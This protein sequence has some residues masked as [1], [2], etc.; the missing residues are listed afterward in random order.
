MSCGAI[1][2]ADVREST[3]ALRCTGCVSIIAVKC[4]CSQHRPG[5]NGGTWWD[6][7]YLKY[8]EKKAE[9]WVLT[10]PWKPRWEILSAVKGSAVQWSQE[11][12]KGLMLC[13]WY[14]P[15]AVCH[16]RMSKIQL[17]PQPQGATQVATEAGGN[18]KIS[19][20]TSLC[21]NLS[22]SCLLTRALCKSSFMWEGLALNFL[23]CIS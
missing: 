13:V 20:R 23:S 4:C 15:A 1:P 9:S 22:N 8:G 12:C 6:E 2:E 10:L 17:V 16:L 11:I 14:F 21:R 5:V 3:A 7:N 18:F 19:R